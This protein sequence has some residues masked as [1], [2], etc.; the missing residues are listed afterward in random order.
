M[1]RDFTADLFWCE[2]KRKYAKPP[3]KPI[4]LWGFSRSCLP[5]THVF[6]T[7]KISKKELPNIDYSKSF[8]LEKSLKE[9]WESIEN[10]ALLWGKLRRVCP[11]DANGSSGLFFSF[12]LKQPPCFEKGQRWKGQVFGPFW[13][14]L[15]PSK[16]G[17]FLPPLEQGKANVFPVFGL[18][19][20]DFA[21]IFSA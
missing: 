16:I 11:T 10:L 6:S 20:W 9:T 7:G 13:A 18:M 8:S 2:L 12:R 1:W 19:C 21:S 5:S 15:F 4:Q 14:G 17:K 3:S